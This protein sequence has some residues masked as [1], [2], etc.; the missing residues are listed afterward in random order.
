MHTH[1]YIYIYI[2]I[3]VCVYTHTHIY[4]YIY[5]DIYI[6]VHTCVYRRVHTCVLACV[7][8]RVRVRVRLCACACA[9]ACVRAFTHARSGPAGVLETAGNDCLLCLKAIHYFWWFALFTSC[10]LSFVFSW[11]HLFFQL[12]L[13]HYVSFNLFIPFHPTNAFGCTFGCIS[14]K[15]KSVSPMHHKIRKASIRF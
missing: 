14:N 1:T 12:M 10:L 15:S 13:L 2:Y 8:V 5:I 11:F 3:Y 9:C 7:H 6:Y 4:I